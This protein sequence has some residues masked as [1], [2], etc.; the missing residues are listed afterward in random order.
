MQPLVDW[1]E[2]QFLV[3]HLWFLEQQVDFEEFLVRHL[4]FL[5]QQVGFEELWFLVREL[6]VEEMVEWE[7]QHFLVQPLVDFEEL[8]FLVR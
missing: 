5:G 2:L 8:W 4:W 3:R 6:L 7:E 1:E